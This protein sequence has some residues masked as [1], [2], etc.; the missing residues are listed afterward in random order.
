MD[1]Y[2]FNFTITVVGMDV[3]NLIAAL[4]E[5]GF[6]AQANEIEEQFIKELN[7]NS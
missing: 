4:D 3:E 5:A 7:D 2:P 6:D 1:Q